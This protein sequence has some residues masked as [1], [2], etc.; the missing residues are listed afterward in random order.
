MIA[1][2]IKYVWF[3]ISYFCSNFLGLGHQGAHPTPLEA[4]QRLRIF[5]LGKGGDI[6]VK[7]PSVELEID[8]ERD[9]SPAEIVEHLNRAKFV[10][11]EKVVSQDVTSHLTLD[12]SEDETA[13]LESQSYLEKVTLTQQEIDEKIN[14]NS[15]QVNTSCC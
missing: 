3:E 7:N 1:D 12:I 4:M 14:S 2:R 5:L 8:E 11:Q 6:L 9:I 15:F 10:E 13:I